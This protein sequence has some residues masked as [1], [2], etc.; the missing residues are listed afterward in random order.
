M[1]RCYVLLASLCFVCIVSC[2]SLKNEQKYFNGDIIQIEDTSVRY[3][4]KAKET[5]LNDVTSGRIAVYDS[6]IFFQDFRYPTYF[7]SVYNYLTG[8]HIGDF[9]DKGNGPDEFVD[10][11]M[12]Y[13]FFY[14]SEDM[15]ALLYSFSRENVIIWN[16]T[17]SIASGMTLISQTNLPNKNVYGSDMF[18]SED[19]ILIASVNIS[20]GLS[21][22]T[23]KSNKV[24]NTI[25]LKN[26]NE[27][28]KN[29]S[30]FNKPILN[31][32]KNPLSGKDFYVSFPYVHPDRKKIVS[33][34]ALIDQINVIDFSDY[35]QNGYRLKNGGSFRDLKMNGGDFTLYYR[36][37]T[38]DDKYIYALYV[39]KPFNRETGIL[40]SDVVH[41][42]DWEG[43]LVSKLD[44]D[45]KANQIYIDSKT[46]ILVI[47][48][49]IQ[50]VV[51]YYEMKD[52][53]KY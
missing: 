33:A 12:I 34:M 47:K 30:Q 22:N 43:N 40:Q 19:S 39:G 15:K 16:I 7:I 10:L 51:Y 4:I 31:D 50:D 9:F 29:F 52:I 20:F 49:E 2:N 23:V 24:Y 14:D 42:F 35:T 13:H 8:K 27:V 18:L 53:L 46:K 41:V 45:H 21:D 26:N 1:N 44:L 28:V 17:E 25:D 32:N 36:G 5:G 37:L 48:D 6:L 3:E 11:S 38:A